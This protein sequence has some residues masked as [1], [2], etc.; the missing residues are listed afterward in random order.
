MYKNHNKVVADKDICFVDIFHDS[1]YVTIQYIK[2]AAGSGDNL[3]YVARTKF[4]HMNPS[5][6]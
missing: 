4:P 6:E 3:V 1:N 5:Q 2:E